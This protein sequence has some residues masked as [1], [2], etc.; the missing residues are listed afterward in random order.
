MCSVYTAETRPL[1]EMIDRI[2]ASGLLYATQYAGADA[3]MLLDEEAPLGISVDLDDVTVEFVD[4]TLDPDDADWLFATAR[5]PAASVLRMEDGSIMLSAST[6]AQWT[7]S[8]EN[9][10]LFRSRYEASRSPV[11]MAPSVRTAFA[12]RSPPPES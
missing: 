12:R 7:A 5:L 6:T 4:R 3:I 10:A 2:T 1:Q 11:P 9:L 8:A